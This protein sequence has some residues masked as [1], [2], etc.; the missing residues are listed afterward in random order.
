M[1]THSIIRK[2]HS[3]IPLSTVFSRCQRA[4]ILLAGTVICGLSALASDTPLPL[5]F[6]MLDAMFVFVYACSITLDFNLRHGK[7]AMVS[8]SKYHAALEQ[9]QQEEQLNLEFANFSMMTF[10]KIC[11]P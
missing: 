6:L 2:E 4:L 5:F 9:L 1:S 10:S 7:S 8:E 11:F 3:S